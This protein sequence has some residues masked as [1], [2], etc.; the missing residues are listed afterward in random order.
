MAFNVDN[1]KGALKFGGTRSSLFEVY[2]SVPQYLTQVSELGRFLVRAAEIPAASVGVVDV[3]YFGRPIRFAGNRT[4]ADWTVT[5]LNDED[6]EIRD[7]MEAWS[8]SINSFSG[9]RRAPGVP[10]NGAGSYKASAIVNQLGK[11]G[12][13]LRQYEFQGMFPTEVAA[14]G[15]DWGTEGIQEFTTTFTYDQW[16]VLPQNS[17]AQTTLGAQ[18]F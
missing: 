9:N 12:S 8:N 6:F 4:F 14:I 11:D 2:L 16:V 7:A 17:A 18:Q 10:D 5:I 3:T 1:L 15:L 13:L